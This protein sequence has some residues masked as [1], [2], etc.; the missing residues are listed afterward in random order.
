MTFRRV[1]SHLRKK[2]PFGE[3]F[4]PSGNR[5]VT[6]QSSQRLYK[7]LLQLSEPSTQ[8][9]P[10][11]TLS[12]VALGNDGE[13]DDNKLEFL[14]KVFCPDAKKALPLIAFVGSIDSVYKRLRYFQASV[15]NAS[16]LDKVLEDTL[17]IVFFFVLGLL[18]LVFMNF[19]P[20]P[21]LV[22]ITSLLGMFT[23]SPQGFVIFMEM[24][25]H[26]TYTFC[27]VSVSFA[28][29]SS[30]SKWVEGI[31]LIAVRR[32]YDLGDRIIITR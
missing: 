24:D 31:L 10:F 30:L 19:N 9:L 12:V 16:K 2:T 1:L 14:R 5:Q 28:L 15:A 7:K 18:I 27:P 17:N 32:P 4:G 23:K 6:I 29:G 26:L 20:W 8:S 22:S 3:S 11:E 13:M 21:V 25:E